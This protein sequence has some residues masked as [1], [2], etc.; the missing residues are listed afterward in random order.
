MVGPLLRLVVREIAVIVYL[1]QVH[2]EAGFHID[3][4]QLAALGGD[5]QTGKKREGR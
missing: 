4:D 3:D 5:V 1:V 2:H